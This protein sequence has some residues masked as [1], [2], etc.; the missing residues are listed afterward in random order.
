MPT[1]VFAM[2]TP[3]SPPAPAQPGYVPARI[4][5]ATSAEQLEQ[6]FWA[7]MR[8]LARRGLVTREEFFAELQATTEGR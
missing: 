3:S 6:K 7:L 5:S 8:V 4:D 2:T 1:G